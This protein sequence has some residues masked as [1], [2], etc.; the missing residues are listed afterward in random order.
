MALRRRRLGA[1]AAASLLCVLVLAAVSF[2]VSAVECQDAAAVAAAGTSRSRRCVEVARFPLD[3]PRAPAFEYV[4]DGL[5]HGR[6]NVGPFRRGYCLFLPEGFPDPVDGSDVLRRVTFAEAQAAQA[7]EKQTGGVD[8]SDLS[9]LS[10]MSLPT[11]SPPDAE[12]TAGGAKEQQCCPPNWGAHCD[13][14]KMPPCPAGTECKWLGEELGPP[15]CKPVGTAQPPASQAPVVARRMQTS[16]DGQ[17]SGSEASPVE[18]LMRLGMHC[19]MQS[20]S[21]C[22]AQ[23]EWSTETERCVPS[24]EALAEHVRAAAPA[25]ANTSTNSNASTQAGEESDSGGALAAILQKGMLC[26]VN[27]QEKCLPSEGCMWDHAAAS[28]MISEDAGIQAVMSLLAPDAPNLP[29]MWIAGGA[30]ANSSL[31]PTCDDRVGVA[32]PCTE[33]FSGNLSLWLSI[34]PT[35]APPRTAFCAVTELPVQKCPCS[36][37]SCAAMLCSNGEGEGRLAAFADGST[38]ARV[39]LSMPVHITP[40]ADTHKV[41][42][43][44]SAASTAVGSPAVPGAP[45][46]AAPASLSNK[47]DEISS[48]TSSVVAS[49]VA[50][51]TGIS[52]F[53]MFLA[54]VAVVFLAVTVF[55]GY[56]RMSRPRMGMS[57]QNDDLPLCNRDTFHGRDFGPA[58]DGFAALDG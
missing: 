33:A 10:A 19:S 6:W 18:L 56:S 31:A 42:H 23:C 45:P 22:T 43:S 20:E 37:S 13:A 14:T 53:M 32:E 52:P 27:P 24:P 38:L 50:A 4:G 25:D 17:E 54:I 5:L 2:Q 55:R 57:A 49:D 35:P 48:A 47:S 44:S 51:E 1:R 28:C 16:V 3:A 12:L 40:A 46:S 26:S 36:S 15:L 58:V 11:P 8:G 9:G 41:H 29:Y 21:T 30:S 39:D 7:L 34:E